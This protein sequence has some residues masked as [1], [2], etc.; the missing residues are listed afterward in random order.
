M[1]AKRSPCWSKTNRL[2]GATGGPSSRDYSSLRGDG[3]A[4]LRKVVTTALI[5]S[6]SLIATACVTENVRGVLV[7]GFSDTEPVVTSIVIPASQD[8]EY[9]FHYGFRYQNSVCLLT[10]EIPTP[11]IPFIEPCDGLRGTGRVSCNDGRRLTLQWALTSCQGGYGRSDEGAESGFFFG[12]GSSEE[13]ARDQ[14]R[15][16]R[17]ED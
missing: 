11:M 2:V 5:L 13:L 4:I 15:K 6:S 8:G 3:A 10:G 7:G 1:M 9:D 16:A 12:F 14:L 17:H